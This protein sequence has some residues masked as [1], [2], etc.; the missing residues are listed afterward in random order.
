MALGKVIPGLSTGGGRG[1]PLNATVR[2][3]APAYVIDRG[4]Y[5]VAVDETWIEQAIE[6]YQRLEHLL[7]T[8]DR[9]VAKVEVTVSSPD[10][11]VQIVVAGDGT[12]RD[13]V[14]NE[15]AMAR[16]AADLS[17]SIQAAVIA[18]ADAARWARDRLRSELF[19][20]YP[21]LVASRGSTPR[22]SR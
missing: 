10:G 8:F 21:D 5:G 7:A 13:V 12:V 20:P 14:V 22:G 17:R 4:G 16:P 1:T 6:R 11:L 15:A 18:A 19:G 2:Y 9:E 3:G